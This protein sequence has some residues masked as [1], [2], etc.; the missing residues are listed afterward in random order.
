MDVSTLWKAALVQ[1]LAVGVIFAVLA[2]ALPKEFFVDWGWIAG[3]AAWM[4]CAA[5][6]ARVLALPLVPTLTGAVLAG[7]PSLLA[8]VVD[9]H[10]LGMILAVGLFALWCGRLPHQSASPSGGPSS[11][12]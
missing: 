2:L 3:P 4:L 6:T 10:A 8:V 1:L 12:V 11:A 7:L 9:A 5:I